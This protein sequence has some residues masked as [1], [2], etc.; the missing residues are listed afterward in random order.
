MKNL[1]EVKRVRLNF[2]MCTR[3]KEGKYEKQNGRYGD[4]RE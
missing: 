4:E 2:M 1:K 3:I